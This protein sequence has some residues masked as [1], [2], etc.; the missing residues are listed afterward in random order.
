MNLHQ[1]KKKLIDA[2][3]N[4]NI[5]DSNQILNEL[6]DIKRVA[7]ANGD[8]LLAKEIWCYEATLKA[9]EAFISAFWE[10]KRQ[11]YYAG[12]RTLE[13]VELIVL[14]LERH[15]SKEFNL[16]KLS[17]IKMYTEKF[18]VLFPYKIFFSPEYVTQIKICSICKRPISI[19]N[20]CGHR[21]GEVY[22]GELCNRIITKS[23]M[24]GISLVTNPLQ[25][26]SV[27]FTTDQEN[28]RTK[29]QYDYHLVK[30]VI[31]RLISPFHGWDVNW[32]KAR[33][34]HSRYAHVNKSSD[35]PCES[36]QKY[37]DCCLSE[38][39]V[40]R[41]HCIVTFHKDFPGELKL[42]EYKD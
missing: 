4:Y 6:L 5:R 27:V 1:I 36:G 8:Q 15:F 31:S 30:Y 9:Q 41:P 3:S 7:V 10:M 34:S 35:C 42:I 28:G 29:D 18:Q 14:S 24:L 26:Y 19:R 38:V 25:K 20:S 11:E 2:E 39:G 40:L 13:Q 21:V 32:T 33:H 23:E 12:W 17:H 37:E 16:Y 22:N